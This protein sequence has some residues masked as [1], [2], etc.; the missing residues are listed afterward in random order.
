M[1]GSRTLAGKS[2]LVTGA[3]GGLGR[4]GA[5]ALA[6]EGARV[7]L[8]DLDGPALERLGEELVATYGRAGADVLPLTADVTVAEQVDAY[9][10][11]TLDAFGR[12]DVLFNN[13]GLEGAVAPT[14][15]YGEPE[16]DRVLQVNV[17]GV[18]LNMRSAIG[19]MLEAGGGSIVNTASGLALRGV[20][21]VCAY[22]ASKHAVLGLTRTAALEY[23]RAAIRVNA[24][25]P[26]PVETSMMHSLERG[27]AAL[28]G[29]AQDA[30]ARFMGDVPMGR[31]GR[32]EE[33]A[34]LVAFLASDAAAFITGAAVSIDGGGSAG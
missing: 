7:A 27:E 3:A 21:H 2:A 17:K 29:S 1:S 6:R 11:H 18:W 4:A 16:F 23:A 20:P 5:R 14:H 8:V 10:E 34:E 19:A 22:V 15:E 30:R 25:C 24:V 9:V 28:G 32:P 31:Y 33:V 26:G 12:L 13:A